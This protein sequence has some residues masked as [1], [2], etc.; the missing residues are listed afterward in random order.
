MFG[1]I[2]GMTPLSNHAT[3]PVRHLVGLIYKPS[4]KIGVAAKK[5]IPG[6]ISKLKT[7]PAFL[8]LIHNNNNNNT[9]R[10]LY[11]S[12][13]ITILRACTTQAAPATPFPERYLQPDGS[14]TPEIFLH[15]DERYSWLTD[16]AGFTVL[17][18]EEGWFVYAKQSDDGGLESTRVRVGEQNPEGLGLQPHIIHANAFLETEVEEDD[19]EEI[20][21]RQLR[22]RRKSP[23]QQDPN[24]KNPCY[25]EQLALLVQFSDHKD[26]I[27]PSPEK[28]DILFNHNGPTQSGPAST[29]SIADVYRANSFDTFVLDTHVTPWIQISKPES[30]AGAGKTGFNLKETR[31]CWAEALEKY[32]ATLPPGALDQFDADG[33][34]YV[35]GLVIVHSGAAAE[36]QGRDCETNAGFKDRIWSHAV[37]KASNFEFLSENGINLGGIKVGRFYVFSGVYDKCPPGGPGTEWETG[38]IAVGVH[39]G[40]HFLGLP[41]LYGKPGKDNGIGNWGFMGTYHALRS[42]TMEAPILTSLLVN[43]SIQV[44]CMAGTSRRI[45]Q[46]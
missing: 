12:L 26:R 6:E 16:A 3:E 20:K 21:G 43:L 37:P 1:H 38:R 18:D 30:Y 36:E 10:I 11:T 22:G 17:E 19:A 41:D 5:A 29:G 34:G 7:I 4:H 45:T 2:P 28:I 39:E 8:L 33:D 32:A 15:G 25:L 35:D 9:M 23:C 24:S 14:Q 13:L 31:E 46:D 40:G 27:L 42:P 44:T